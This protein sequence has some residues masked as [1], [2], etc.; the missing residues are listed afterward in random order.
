MKCE[1]LFSGK[2]KKISSFCRL[3]K[4]PRVIKVNNSR[5]HY[6]YFPTKEILIFHANFLL[7][8]LYLVSQNRGKYANSVDIDQTPQYT[9]SDQGPRCLH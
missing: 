1:N 4:L 8:H 6:T 5:R 9:A 7:T 2:N 3:L